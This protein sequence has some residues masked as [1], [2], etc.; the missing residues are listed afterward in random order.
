MAACGI[1]GRRRA[2]RGSIALVAARGGIDLGGTKIQAVV[3]DAAGGMLG[4]ARRPTPDA[5]GPQ[6]VTAALAETVSEAAGQ[7]GLE[8]SALVGVG[9]GSPGEVDAARGTVAQAR[10]LPDWTAAFP[11]RAP[12]WSPTTT[13]ARATW[14]R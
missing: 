12:A 7:A 14:R 5:G 1:A 4:A 9:V 11:L 6:A 8:T 2:S 13:T 3:I 10:N